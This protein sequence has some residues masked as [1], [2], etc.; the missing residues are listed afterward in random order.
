MEQS[1]IARLEFEV[2]GLGPI[3]SFKNKKRI[4]AYLDKSKKRKEFRNGEYWIAEKSLKIKSLLITLPEHQEWMEQA[5]S[6]LESQLHCALATSGAV[7]PTG[8]SLR[9]LIATL[10]PLDDC[11][12]SFREVTIRSELCEAGNEG[13]TIVIEPL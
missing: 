3:P 10:V 8:V 4:L 9:S 11:W 12:T 6:L 13:A 5:I 2:K 7:I 1:G